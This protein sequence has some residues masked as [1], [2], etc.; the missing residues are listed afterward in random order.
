VL[1]SAIIVFREVLE[2]ALIVAVVM[3]ASRGALGRGRWILAGIVLGIAGACVVAA[4]AGRIA[5][6]L[7]GRG[8]ELFNAAVLL[9]AVAMLAWHNVWMSAHG[10]ELADEMRDLGRDI[11]VGAKP[12]SA[13]LAVTA[14]A[15]LRE[16]AET[17]LFL[18]GLAAGGAG[19][20]SLLGGGAIGLAAGVLLGVLL[21]QGLVRIPLRRFFSV[22]GWIVLLLAAGLAASAADYLNQAGILPTLIG[23]VWDSSGILEQKSLVGQTLHVLIGY[24]GRPSGIALAAYVLTLVAIGILMRLAGGNRVIPDRPLPASGSP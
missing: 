13:M 24:Q 5:D 12:L 17:V 23:E 9:T 8:Q 15:V 11:T 1:G 10:R 3:G 16:G 6:A 7:E 20:A 18:Y 21:Y 19:S 4:F 2:A 14:L 22:T